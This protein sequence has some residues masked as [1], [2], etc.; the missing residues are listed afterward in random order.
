M[1]STLAIAWL[2]CGVVVGLVASLLFGPLYRRRL[3]ERHRLELAHSQQRRAYERLKAAH[4]E[5]TERL[6]AADLRHSQV[7]AGLKRAHVA[8]M[9]ALAEESNRLLTRSALL[10]GDGDNLIS[11]TSFEEGR[12]RL[13]RRD[14]AQRSVRRRISWQTRCHQP[15]E[16]TA[17]ERA[18]ARAG[19]HWRSSRRRGGWAASPGSRS[20]EEGPGRVHKELMIR[21]LFLS[22]NA[23]NVAPCRSTMHFCK[24]ARRM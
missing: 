9:R 16:L 18:C 13:R 20:S 14:W 17:G 10:P 23:G 12:R 21:T 5:L 19:V 2:L 1:D 24:D 4:Q 3:A 11:G 7:V 15:G 22:A 6:E 8:Q